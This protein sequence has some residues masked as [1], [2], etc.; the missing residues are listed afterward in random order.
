MYDAF[1]WITYDGNKG[2]VSMACDYYFYNKDKKEFIIKNNHM[3]I[4][5][6]NI[7]EHEGYELTKMINDNVRTQMIDIN[8]Y[9]S[10]IREK[11]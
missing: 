9:L 11:I 3:Y 1:I 2:P 10:L 6:P 4:A 7:T 5:I 8:H